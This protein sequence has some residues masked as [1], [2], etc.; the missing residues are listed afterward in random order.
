[1]QDGRSIRQIVYTNMIWMA[2]YMGVILHTM[3]VLFFVPVPLPTF[4]FITVL[5]HLSYITCFLLVR[6]NLSHTGKHL[7][8]IST[9]IAIGT[10]DHLFGKNTFTFMHL[11]AFLPAAMNMFSFKKNKLTVILYT[12][13]PLA[14]TLISRLAEYQ[15]SSF[16]Q[17][18]TASVTFLTAVNLVLAFMLFVSFATYMVLNNQAKQ[19]KL[20]L[21]SI[22][23]QATLDNSAGAIWSIDK[24]FYLMA[25]NTKYAESLEKEFGVTGLKRGINIKQH[26]IWEKLPL[27]LKNQYYAVLAGQEIQHEIILNGRYYEI[28]GVPIYDTKGNI[29]GATFDSRDITV[30]KKA[31]KMLLKAKK[32][33]EDATIAKTRFLSNMSHELRT[34][35]NGIIG[36]TRIMQDEKML[37]DQLSNFR[38]LQDLSEHTLQIINNILDLSKIEAGKASLDNHRFNLRRFINKINSIFSGTAQLKGIKFIIEINGQADIYVRG[39]EVRLSQVLIN[40][41]GNAFKFTEKGS[42]TFKTDIS[43]SDS[44]GFY[45]VQFAVTDTGIGIKKEHISKI[46]ESFSQADSRTT[47][48][49]GGTGLGLSIAEKILNLMNSHI[50]VESE[51]GKGSAFKFDL[52]LTKSSYIPLKKELRV[53]PDDNEL[54]SM[55]IL[56]AEDN[57]VNQLVAVR[58]LEKWKSRVTVACNGKEAVEYVHQ[59]KYD[60]ILMDLD[61]P[62]MDGYESTAIIKESFPGIPVIALTAASFDDMDNYLM[63]KGFSDVVQKPFIPDDLYNKIM[64]VIKRA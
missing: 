50:I 24:N 31:E 23:L 7:L 49:F 29:G 47:R 34:P 1:M 9:Y 55:R 18:S 22:G 42:I 40:L 12:S 20:L 58:I 41:I 59:K 27:S 35:L 37:P 19:Q 36:I 28:K 10:V 56:L 38:T 44:T 63:N 64:S 13:F 11:F 2:S 33:A 21:Q 39:D 43:E 6:H 25:T 62:V 30:K 15:Y 16:T 51:C 32:A 14:Y 26:L 60:V 53:I 46:F 52:S 8:I 45:K 4:L 3:V 17:F 57:K 5:I 54:Q 61:M 48:S